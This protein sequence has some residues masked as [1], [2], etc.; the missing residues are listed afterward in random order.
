MEKKTVKLGT[1]T[2]Y[3]S[4]IGNLATLSRRIDIWEGGYFPKGSVLKIIGMDSRGY[5]LKD[6]EGNKVF[7]SCWIL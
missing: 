1:M 6:S 5:I 3:A 7:T 4:E 2:K